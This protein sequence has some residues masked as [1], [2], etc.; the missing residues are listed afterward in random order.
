MPE[1]STPEA[2]YELAQ[3]AYAAYAESTGGKNFRGE[4]MP[5]FDALPGAIKEAWA[6]AS[7]A[8]Y[9]TFFSVLEEVGSRMLVG[10]DEDA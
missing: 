5:A 9:A 2:Q 8:L 10:E 7:D 4:D 3:I 6:A 1:T